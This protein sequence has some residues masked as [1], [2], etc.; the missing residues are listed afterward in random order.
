MY[1]TQH[2][3]SCKVLEERVAYDTSK[4]SS[5]L[6]FIQW[7]TSH[8][9]SICF[10]TFGI[11]CFFYAK[12]LRAHEKCIW[13]ILWKLL[14][15]I[16]T[17]SASNFYLL[18]KY[19]QAKLIHRVDLEAFPHWSRHK[20]QLE[21]S[22]VRLGDERHWTCSRFVQDREPACVSPGKGLLLLGYF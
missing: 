1:Y 9:D 19:C 22:T 11:C 16:S 15:T 6:F 21:N 4:S 5:S 3:V 18:N 2:A 8:K 17:G 20:V 13:L 7:L 14:Q 10:V 12:H